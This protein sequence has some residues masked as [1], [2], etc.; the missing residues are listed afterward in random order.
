[1][2][3]FQKKLSLLAVVILGLI[4]ILVIALWW[5]KQSLNKI[6]PEPQPTY[7]SQPKPNK[8]IVNVN[9]TQPLTPNQEK[10]K[11]II[12]ESDLDE[13]NLPG[14]IINEKYLKDKFVSPAYNRSGKIKHIV[15]NKNQFVFT[16]DSL[17]KEKTYTVI[18]DNNTKISIDIIEYIFIDEQAEDPLEV[19][20]YNRK[21]DF[22]EL[23]AGDS[24]RIRSRDI[25]KD[26]SFVA[27]E[28]TAKRILTI[29]K[30]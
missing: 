25:I 3:D 1:M 14:E 30:N 7:Q 6:K 20:R 12:P 2:S 21:A 10:V 15:Y 24:L 23:Q 9:E 13:F 29:Y 18:I 27:D 22:N 19:K 26:N 4:I 8:P 16:D 11:F 5:Q 28:I 17:G